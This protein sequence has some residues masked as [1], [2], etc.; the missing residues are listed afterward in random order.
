MQQRGGN[1]GHYCPL[2]YNLYLISPLNIVRNKPISTKLAPITAN[3]Q[4]SG[5]MVAIVV[6]VFSSR[7]VPTTK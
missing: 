3:N 6:F 7:I 5:D 2:S 1:R 4:S